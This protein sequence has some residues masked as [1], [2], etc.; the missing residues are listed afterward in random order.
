VPR[1]AHNPEIAGSGMYHRT[2]LHG[3]SISVMR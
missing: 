1:C 3:V 2:R